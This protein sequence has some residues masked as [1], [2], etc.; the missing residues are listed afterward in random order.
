MAS[1]NGTSSVTITGTVTEINN[2]LGGVNLSSTEGTIVY[3]PNTDAPPASATLTLLVDDTGDTGTGGPLTATDTATINIAAVNDAPVNTFTTPLAITEDTPTRLTGISVADADIGGSN[4]T[5]TL[6]VPGS[7]GTLTAIAG[8]GVAVTGSGTASIQLVGTLANVNTFLANAAG[9]V[10]YNPVANSTTDVTL[11]VVSSDGGAT[12]T[13]GTLTDT[14]TVTLDLQ[15]VNDAPTANITN[16]TFNATEQ[17]NLTLADLGISLGSIADVDAGGNDISATLSVTYGILTITA[18]N[19]GITVASGNGT[20]S[21]TITGTVTE[22][23]NLLGGVNLSST[24]GTIVYNPNTDAPPASA[25]L[26]LLVDDTGDTGTGG[27]LTATDTATINIAA[28]ND[29][30]VNTFTT[31][32]A[33][34]EDTPTRLTGISVADADIGGSNLTVT[35]SV[36]GSSGTLTAI[37]GGGVAVTGSGTAS[38]QLVGTLANV[39]TFLANAA[40]GVTYNPV[41][42][43]TTDV[44]LTVV[45]SDGGATGTGGTLTDTDTVTLDL[46]AVNDAPTANITNATFNATEQTNLTLADLGISLGSIADVDAGGNDISATL[47]V[48]Y[49]ILTITA[50]NSGI[51]VASGNGTSSVTITGTVTEIN[52]LLGGVNLSSTEGTIVYNPN[53]DAPP[54]SATLTLLVDD[55][56]D[57]GSG[58]AMTATDTA[59]INI[60]AVNDLPTTNA[61]SGSG[62]EDATSIA[63]SLSGADVDGTVASFR[64]T[65]LPGNG[66]LYSDAALTSAIAVNGTVTATGN[67]ATVYFVPAAN[68][69]GAPTFQYTAIDNDGGVDASPATATITVNAVNDAPTASITPVSYSATEQTNLNLHG[70][71]LSVADID[72]GVNPISITLSVSAGILTVAIGSTGASIGSGNGTSSVVINGTLTQLN[73]FLAGNNSATIVYNANTDNPPAT[74]T[75]TL[76]VDDTGDTGSGGAMTATDTATINIAAVND[77]PT[78]NAGSGSGNED[79]TSIAVSLSGADVDGTVAS[80]RIT[81]LPGNGT[82]YSDAALTSAIAVNGTVTATGN[83]ATVYFVPAANFNGAPTFQYTAIDNDG[84]VDASPATAT[85]TVNAV[86][87]APTD[88]AFTG[89]AALSAGTSGANTTISDNSRLFTLLATDV[90]DTS[91]TYSFGGSSSIGVTVGGTGETFDFQTQA[92]GN[93]ETTALSYSTVQTISLTTTRAN[94]GDVNYTEAVT[95]RLGLNTAGDTID[96]SATT[97]DQ[98]IYGFGGNDILTGGSGADWI[99]GGAGDDVINGAQNDTLLDGGA[100]TDTLQIGAN[101]T[102]TSNAQIANIENVTLT[103]A[104][105][106]NLANQTEGFTIT[107][108]SGIDSIT[109]GG[110]ADTIVGAQNDTLLDGGGGADTL[111]VG[112]NFT[113][114]SNAQIANIENVTLTAAATLN[115]SNQT[116]GFT[117]TGSSGIDSITGGGGVDTI[118]GAQNDTLLD[119]SGGADTLQVG[120][121]FTSTSNAQIANIENVTLTAAVTLNLSNQTE[122]FTIAGSSGDDTIVAGSGNDI[123][124]GGAGQDTLTGGNGTDAFKLDGSTTANYDIITDFSSTDDIL[125]FINFSLANHSGTAAIDQVRTVTV[126]GGGGSTISSADLVVFNIAA[127][128]AD[129]AAEINTLLDNQNGTFN[130]G[131]FVLAYTDVL[132]GAGNNVA[133]YYDPDADGTGTAPSLVAVFSNYTSVTASGVPNVASDYASVATLADP[134][135]L[136]LGAPGISFKTLDNGVHF[137]INADG[138]LD[139]VAWTRNGQDGL[140]A[141]D[142]DHSGKIE[143]GNELF[144]PTFNGGFFKD[145]IAALASLDANED[146]V[147]DSND[148]AFTDL[149]VWQDANN[150]GI[151]DDGELTKL[152][153]LGI[154]SIDLAVTPNTTPIDGQNVPFAGSF[155]YADG[156]KGTFV[157]V[158]FETSLGQPDDA[159]AHAPAL[160]GTDGADVFQLTDATAAS[161]IADFNQSQG[162]IIDVSALFQMA[163]GHQLGEYVQHVGCDLR[164]DVDGAANGA[165][166]VTVATSLPTAPGAI[167]IMHED[168]AH[169][170]QVATL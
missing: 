117:I 59:I 44:T 125:N 142:V 158:D 149:V 71:G 140:L 115:L 77:L 89:N 23:N 81:S 32:L 112:A 78:T 84:G 37:A 163:D 94:D 118:V 145:G 16:A 21:V 57:T 38:I 47:S 91:F 161:I 14:D 28:V 90:D 169:A 67:A 31:P 119:G 150:D 43:S 49:G 137:D 153:D 97:N 136:D 170:A 42:N 1:G 87:D 144:T 168:A 60:A 109:G 19:S 64:I 113:D 146:G 62:N 127:N 159:S 52:N 35:L 5:V 58:G 26:T 27:P 105:T 8:G 164:V 121:N 53:T 7:S 96:G 85:I 80:F 63:V 111:Q 82:L 155:T 154:A 101:F 104:A 134:I 39:N 166:F 24:E 54:A 98:V 41:A 61:G 138:A 6:S 133:L 25:T 73:N 10:T 120:A 18:G 22:I 156:T 13:G 123:L 162:D 167:T 102:D 12:G 88:I 72:A 75:L 48:T 30:P 76:F 68:F 55:T 83:A 148:Q 147:I 33:I 143:N 130:G 152:T 15:A 100:N 93:V 20:S 45:S 126:T 11:T 70:T 99:S 103:A 79:A 106:L 95:L 36:P 165:N 141:L 74:A 17:T 110:G 66:T 86:N 40:G 51:T 65:S 56:G 4:L 135:V 46:Q 129:T 131:V 116:E 108:S 151:S 34:T 2:L 107:G 124:I 160:H 132:G 9:G 92:N 3:N 114:T 29:A 50:G 157:E 122:G 139:Q 69:N 128:S